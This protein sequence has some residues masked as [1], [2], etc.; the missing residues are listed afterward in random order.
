MRFI[1]DAI[2]SFS[3][4]FLIRKRAPLLGLYSYRCVK[5]SSNGILLCRYYILFSSFGSLQCLVG[6][7]VA[8]RTKAS[9]SMVHL[10]WC[11]SYFGCVWFIVCVHSLAIR[12]ENL[13]LTW[14][15]RWLAIGVD[16]ILG[17]LTD[18][19]CSC[20]VGVQGFKDCS[21]RWGG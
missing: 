21:L 4:N 11:I 1:F 20:G 5:V 13:W 14:Y 16:L 17:I 6:R 7:T 3:V 12:F 19:C 8:C 9:S 15:L 2:I 10:V 18:R